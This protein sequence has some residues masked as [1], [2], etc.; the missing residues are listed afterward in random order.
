MAKKTYEEM[1]TNFRSAYGIIES[2]GY[3]VAGVTKSVVE[4]FKSHRDD[5]E[6]VKN[7]FGNLAHPIDFARDMI[8]ELGEQGRTLVEGLKSEFGEVPA[9]AEAKEQAEKVQAGKEAQEQAEKAQ[10]EKEAKDQAEKAQAEKEA[11]EQAE[12]AQAEEETK[13]QK[14]EKSKEPE[15]DKVRD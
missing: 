13:E 4:Y 6:S 3:D 12:K 15:K 2:N 11:K 7:E 8:T 5:W 1:K 9:E 14:E 10:A